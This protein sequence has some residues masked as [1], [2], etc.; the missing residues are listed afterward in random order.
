MSM[1]GERGLRVER[2]PE[3]G[4]GLGAN[5]L[6]PATEVKTY[7]P[8]QVIQVR[9]S[10]PF[11]F[12]PILDSQRVGKLG[13]NRG[14]IESILLGGDVQ[15]VVRFEVLGT[16]ISGRIFVIRVRG[17]LD[18]E[19]AK[20]QDFPIIHLA[21]AGGLYSFDVW[22][23]GLT[24]G[25]KDTATFDIVSGEK[26]AQAVFF[27]PLGPKTGYLEGWKTPRSDE[28]SHVAFLE[29]ELPQVQCRLELPP[30]TP[31]GQ[32]IIPTP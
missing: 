20:E 22:L 29:P 18:E 8:Q 10:E 19:M 21:S 4:A 17:H 27:Y 26:P 23:S 3:R 7:P 25:I 9:P 24:E 6:P 11:S 32:P 31:P 12:T 30:E 14:F 28:L 16:P 15:D 1:E 5:A 2:G 13:L